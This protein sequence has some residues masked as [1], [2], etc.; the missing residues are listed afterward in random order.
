MPTFSEVEL[1]RGLKEGIQSWIV[2]VEGGAAAAEP[3]SI[4]IYHPKCPPFGLDS[5]WSLCT[6]SEKRRQGYAHRLLTYIRG[7]TTDT[8]FIKA[9]SPELADFYKSIGYFCM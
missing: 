6:K 2:L 5:V 4:A 7:L 8:L 1:M 9:D 3:I